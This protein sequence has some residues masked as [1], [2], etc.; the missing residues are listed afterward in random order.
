MRKNTDSLDQTNLQKARYS[1][2][3]L[4]VSTFMK[5]FGSS[6]VKMFPALF[7]SSEKS[8]KLQRTNVYAVG[9]NI[10]YMLLP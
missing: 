3:A 7:S 8:R 10:Y 4:K 6:S 9:Q 2:E 5:W 1:F